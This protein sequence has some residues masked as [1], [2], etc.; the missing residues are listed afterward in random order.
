MIGERKTYFD[1][2]LSKLNPFLFEKPKFK[3][4]YEKNYEYNEIKFIK[5]NITFIGYF[6]SEKYFNEYYNDIIE[7][8]DLNK[9]Q[10][11]ITNKYKKIIQIIFL[12]IL[13]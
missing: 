6:Q 7:I 3:K 11:N 2:F 13:D 9:I 12:Y 8:I 5:K 1:E 4:Y 10:K